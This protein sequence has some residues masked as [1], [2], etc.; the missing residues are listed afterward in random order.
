VK[1]DDSPNNLKALCVDCHS[2]EEMHEHL[3]VKKADRSL[4]QRLRRDQSVYRAPRASSYEQDDWELAFE[5]ADPAV[6]GL[7]YELQAQEY[8]VPEVGADIIDKATQR[9]IY[10]NVELAWMDLFEVVVLE[11]TEESEMLKN[12]G[13]K[14]FTAQ[15]LLDWLNSESN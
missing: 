14:V 10:S 4:I 12:V 15:E 1:G 8:P 13:W 5:T 7:L 11:K 3:F 9:V 6:H 2:K